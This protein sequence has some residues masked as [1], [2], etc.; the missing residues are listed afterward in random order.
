V[1]AFL[2]RVGIFL[3]SSA[4]GLI[5]ADLIL[6]GFVIHWGNPLGFLLAIVI[7]TLLQSVLAPWILRLTTRHAPAL[8][9]GIGIVSTFVSLFVVVVVPFAGL[10]ISDLATWFLAPLL[11]WVVTALAT[12]IIPRLLVKDRRDQKKRAA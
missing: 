7:F 4:L 9:G 5:L 1:I 10:G 6:P 3:G 11:V 8:L 12:W 2:I